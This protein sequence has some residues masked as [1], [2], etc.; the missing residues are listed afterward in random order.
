MPKARI[1]ARHNTAWPLPH[2]ELT[3]R[4]K[5]TSFIATPGKLSCGCDPP[6][7]TPPEQLLDI[8]FERN[9]TV[10]C[11]V[12]REHMFARPD[13]ELPPFAVGKIAEVVNHFVRRSCDEDMLS[14]NKDRF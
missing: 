8:A 2:E 7:H 13:R 4:P 10:S 5:I 14:W 6:R 11:R 3:A 1:R 12:S 9:G